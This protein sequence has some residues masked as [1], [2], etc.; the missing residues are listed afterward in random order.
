MIELFAFANG[1]DADDFGVG[2]EGDELEEFVLRFGEAEAA[3][4]T[5][6]EDDAGTRGLGATDGDGEVVAIVV[7]LFIGGGGIVDAHDDGPGGLD[8][9]GVDFGE[10]FGFEVNAFGGGEIEQVHAG[11]FAFAEHLAVVFDDVDGE[12]IGPGGFDGRG[13]K[14]EGGR[15]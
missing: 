8:V 10:P 11:E 6:D 2:I 14:A 13:Q 15:G 9:G 5:I 1:F 3:A 7:A 12:A 4:V